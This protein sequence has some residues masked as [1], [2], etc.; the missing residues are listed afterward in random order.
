[1]K[2]RNDQSASRPELIA[3][4]QAAGLR[5]SKARVAALQA[6]R[7]GLPRHFEVED[8]RDALHNQGLKAHL[9]T[10][11]N[12]LNDFTRVGL[13]RRLTLAN[14]AVFYDSRTDAHHHLYIEER[15][16]L[17]DIDPAEVEIRDDGT[18]RLPRDLL[19]GKTNRVDLLVTLKR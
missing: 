4:L 18:I 5:K 12:C 16:E 3:A 14:G 7:S 19:Q 8:L 2:N 11:Y 9:S 17:R 13:L 6:L 10:V 1:M 15:Q